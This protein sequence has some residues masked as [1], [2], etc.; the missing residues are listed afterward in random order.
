MADSLPD[1]D[2]DTSPEPSKVPGGSQDLKDQDKSS[3]VEEEAVTLDLQPK[4]TEVFECPG[5]CKEY[6]PCGSDDCNALGELHITDEGDEGEG[7]ETSSW[8]EEGEE[9]VHT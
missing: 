2:M 9:I 3:E 4:G 6:K 1:E 5:D 7:I 8:A